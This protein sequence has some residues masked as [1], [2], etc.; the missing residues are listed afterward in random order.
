MLKRENR[1][2]DERSEKNKTWGRVITQLEKEK[3]RDTACSNNGP[4]RVVP[5]R[6]IHSQESHGFQWV[7]RR[8]MV[9]GGWGRQ[10]HPR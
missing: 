3:E 8:T 6:S 1:G 5:L 2:P 4:E 7:T 10:P 9:L